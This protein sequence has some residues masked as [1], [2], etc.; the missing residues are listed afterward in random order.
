MFANRQAAGLELARK[1]EHQLRL[2]PRSKAAMLVA[3]LPRGGV[4]VALEVARKLSCPLEIIVA[5]KLPFPGQPEFALGA[6]SSD[7]IVILNPA[8]P[9]SSRSQAYIEEQRAKLLLQ[10]KT[11]ENEYYTLAGKQPAS[12]IDKYVVIVDDGIATG[13]TALAAVKSARHRGARKVVMASPVTSTE[14]H[15]LLSP[16]CD[17]VVAVSTPLDFSAVGQHYHDFNQ[18][19]DEEVV[20]ALRESLRFSTE[21][22]KQTTNDWYS[23]H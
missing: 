13:M 7:G 5:K 1:L 22:Q 20:A 8:V 23:A 11:L 17:A 21:S 14:S 19:S 10:T 9:V 12:F 16:Y 2:E 18:T 15:R 3:G 4:P 6:V